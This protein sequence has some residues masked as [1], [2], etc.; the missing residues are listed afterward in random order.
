M[1]RMTE[2]LDKRHR[3]PECEDKSSES[4]AN[5]FSGRRPRTESTDNRRWESGLRIDILEFQGSGQ[6]EELL[7]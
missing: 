5:P 2:L 4:F 7:D 6:L 3:T 1:A